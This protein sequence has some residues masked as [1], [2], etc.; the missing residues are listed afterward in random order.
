MDFSSEI[1]EQPQLDRADMSLLYSNIRVIPPVEHPAWQKYFP[2]RNEEILTVSLYYPDESIP[3]PH[4]LVL[5]IPG[6]GFTGCTATGPQID[7]AVEF[8]ENGFVAHCS[9]TEPGMRRT[10]LTRRRNS[11]L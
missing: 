5:V 3:G 7:R 2:N 6:G 1:L 10:C 8:A 9:S 4:P 11:R